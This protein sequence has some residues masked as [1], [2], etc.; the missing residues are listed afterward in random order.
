MAPPCDSVPIREGPEAR[1]EPG[2]SAE[3]GEVPTGCVWARR[4]LNTL[5]PSPASPAHPET[6]TSTPEPHQ[7]EGPQ[8]QGPGKAPAHRGVRAG[9]GG[10]DPPGSK[11]KGRQ[12]AATFTGSCLRQTTDI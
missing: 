9:M 6:H 10:G 8:R 4:G 11:F 1:A 3:G 7:A 12:H 2:N 5:T